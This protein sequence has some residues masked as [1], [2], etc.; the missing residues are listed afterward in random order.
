[1]EAKRTVKYMDEKASH[2]L[3]IINKVIPDDTN[4]GKWQEK[5]KMPMAH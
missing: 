4:P 1:M 3:D 5:N 2:Y